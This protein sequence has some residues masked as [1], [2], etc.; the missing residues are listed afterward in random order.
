M[1][2]NIDKSLLDVVSNKLGRVLKGNNTTIPILN[3]VKIV[4]SSQSV[5]FFASNGN[6]SVLVNEPIESEGRAD[7]VV[8]RE[9]AICIPKEAFKVLS[10]LRKGSVTIELNNEGTQ[11]KFSQ[12]KTELDYSAFDADEFPNFI[13]NEQPIGQFLL[14]YKL[15]EDL[16]TK[17][18]FAAATSDSRPVLKG[19]NIKLQMQS[20]NQLAFNVSCTDSHRLAKYESVV[21]LDASSPIVEF[22]AEATFLNDV[23]KSFSSEHNVAINVYRNTVLFVNDNVI[24]CTILLEGNYPN[25]ERLIPQPTDS[26]LNVVINNEE[27][28]ETLNLLKTLKLA[29]KETKTTS[30]EAIVTIMSEQMII[31]S[32]NQNGSISK[33]KEEIQLLNSVNHELKIAFN[34]N[35]VLEAMKTI[36]TENVS[37][38][39]HGAM[40]PFLLK[41]AYPS[42]AEISG[43]LT[44]LV[45]PV[46]MY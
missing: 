16:I 37:I 29:E 17:T 4:V 40:K 14:S 12:K 21:P 31:E 1:K 7:L 27:I 45:L 18:S 2:F 32:R 22:T 42:G 3:S 38:E 25:T 6:D 26:T 43:H 23:I 5:A 13:P 19:I 44:Q 9:G 46:R 33:L 30:S 10:K 8:E 28:S 39:F 20:N 24:I 15:F 41:P 36:E 34:G 35:Y 11:V